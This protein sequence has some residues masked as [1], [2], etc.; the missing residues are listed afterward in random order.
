MDDLESLSLSFLRAAA[1]IEPVA[2]GIVERN[3]KA[4]QAT[5]R[6]TW[7][8]S[9][10]RHLRKLGDSVTYDAQGTEA[11]I[12]PIKGKGRQGSL[13]HIIEFGSINSNAHPGG[14]PAAM[15]QAPVFLAEITVAAQALLARPGASIGM[16]TSNPSRYN[17]PL[18]R[19][20][21]V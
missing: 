12:G 19:R 9:G 14:G 20:G 10:S 4:V 15:K 8:W 21:A 18:G 17:A 16:E 7:P 6:A 13:G 5:W 11:E 3:A 1:A 2:A